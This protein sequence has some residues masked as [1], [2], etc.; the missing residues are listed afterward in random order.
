MANALFS[1]PLYLQL[2]DNLISRITSGEWKP[3][4]ALK[5]EIELAR[6]YGVS[7]GT[8]RKALSV[9]EDARLITRRQGR[10]SFVADTSPAD[11]QDRY[12]NIFNADGTK[13]QYRV[14]ESSID[15]MIPD[16]LVQ[17]QLE[18]G[19]DERVFRCRQVHYLGAD[20]AAF[21]EAFVPAS[22]FP[23][24][25][26]G[27][28]YDLFAVAKRFG[29]LLGEGHEKISFSPVPAAVAKI[30]EVAATAPVA[31]MARIIF[32]IDGR[33]VECRTIWRSMGDSY[34]H[35]KLG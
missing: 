31:A 3:G 25:D 20:V 34:Y 35:A 7:V 10:G 24:L 22:V 32:G 5:N 6:E 4:C 11:F 27:T 30:L 1:T 18:C 23:G 13:Q 26:D 14:R 15:K 21:E 33:P 29:V 19:M 9:I 12:S 2:V 17:F 8:M 16:A 28:D